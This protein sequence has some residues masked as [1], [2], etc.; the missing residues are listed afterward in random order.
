[1]DPVTQK[2]SVGR[3]VH[4]HASKDA[5]AEAALVIVVHSDTCINVSKCNSGGTWGTATSLP[6]EG[7]IPESTGAFWR[8]PPRV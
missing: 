7:S 3:I 1:M 4:F 6:L 8:W 2:P 5:P